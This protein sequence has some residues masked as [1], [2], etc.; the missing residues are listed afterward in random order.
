VLLFNHFCQSDTYIFE[1]CAV[2]C[3]SENRMHEDTCLFVQERE[4]ER[5]HS[6][7]FKVYPQ[8]HDSEV[9]TIWR[10]CV[11]SF[12]ETKLNDCVFPVTTTELEGV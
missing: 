9:N 7:F 11:C 2:R 8:G 12:K 6:F 3:A 4:R 1:W 5:L 10:T